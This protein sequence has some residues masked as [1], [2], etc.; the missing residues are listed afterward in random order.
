MS[1]ILLMIATSSLAMAAAPGHAQAIT[2]DEALAMRA[3]IE[4]LRAQVTALEARLNAAV[5]VAVAPVAPPPPPVIVPASGMITPASFPIAPLPAAL[6]LRTAGGATLRPRGRF[7]LDVGAINAP[8]AINDAGLGTS[9]EIR[10]VYLG[11][12]GTI[13]G[14]FGYRIEAD[15]ADNAVTLTDAYITYASGPVTFTV[16]QHKPFQGLE[17]ITSDL[18]TSFN[19][20]ASFAGAFGFE[21]RVGASAVYARGSIIVQAGLFADDVSAL[22]NASNNSWSAD[23]RIIFAPRIGTTQLHFG[24]SAHSRTFNDA[25]TT[26]RY[27]ARP[28]VHTTD[29]RLVDTG[30]FAATGETIVG[31]EAAAI[32]GRFHIA[33]ES[34]WLTARRAGSADPGFNGGYAEAGLFLTNDSR[35]W[36]RGVFD[37][38]APRNAVGAVEINLRYDWLDLR[39]AAAAITGGEQAIYAAGLTWILRDNVR[40]L[41]SYGHVVVNGARVAAGLDRDYSADAVALRAQVDF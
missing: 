4:A 27:R 21:R 15:F 17:E 35:S 10:R 41:A 23:G 25:S 7:Q 20:R 8:D 30:A 28:F 37:R 11:F 31:L 18:F 9:A 22:A 1:K 19:E 6:E 14:G 32:H 38:V 40:V 24:A 13:P 29:T 34:Q 3:Q 16:G 2:T 36:R 26:A 5:P 39:D 33:A 12:D